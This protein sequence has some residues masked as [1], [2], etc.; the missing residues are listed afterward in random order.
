L[1]SKSNY[2][3]LL[4]GNRLPGVNYPDS[5]SSGLTTKRTS[6]KVAEQGRRNRI[7]E[8]LKEMQALIPK[9]SAQ[10]PGGKGTPAAD[11][12]MS[13]DVGDGDGDDGGN[14]NDGGAKSSASKAATVELANDY[15]KRM[16]KD[17]ANQHARIERLEHEKAELTRRLQAGSGTEARSSSGAE[18]S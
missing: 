7:N 11:A 13:P 16:Q 17:F 4:E 15:I 1:A 3:N 18:S 8:A 9:R 2:Q 10:S 14:N 5:L 12:A 6:H